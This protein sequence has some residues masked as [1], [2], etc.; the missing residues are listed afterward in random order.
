MKE[1]KRRYTYNKCRNKAIRKRKRNGRNK[2]RKK[3]G[4]NE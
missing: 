1:R 2:E 4:E 3:G